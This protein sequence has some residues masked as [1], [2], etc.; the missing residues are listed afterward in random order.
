MTGATDLARLVAAVGRLGPPL[1]CVV[2]GAWF[3]D[4][5]GE[6]AA[7]GLLARSLFLGAGAEVERAGPCL[8]HLPGDGDAE[9]LLAGWAGGRLR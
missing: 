2:D 3:D 7:A 6:I 9:R 5:A 8:V 4:V 1:F